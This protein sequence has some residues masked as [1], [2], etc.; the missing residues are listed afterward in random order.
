MIDFIAG[1]KYWSCA[2]SIESMNYAERFTTPWEGI[3]SGDEKDGWRLH[4][5]NSETN[6]IDQDSNATAIVKPESS[7]YHQIFHT[8]RKAADYY[9]ELANEEAGCLR[10]QANDLEERAFNMRFG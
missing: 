7:G 4:R 6:I 10:A 8:R 3:L 5:F 1:Q 2:P 9:I